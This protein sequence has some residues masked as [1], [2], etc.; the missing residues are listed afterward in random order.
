MAVLVVAAGSGAAWPEIGLPVAFAAAGYA[1]ISLLSPV[2][3]VRGRVL[4]PRAQH[5]AA[6]LVAGVLL[7]IVGAGEGLVHGCDLAKMLEQRLRDEIDVAR[8]G[9]Q[10]RLG[11][12]FQ[13]CAQLVCAR[14]RIV[15]LP[16]AHAVGVARLS[17]FAWHDERV[18]GW[19]KAARDDTVG[20]GTSRAAIPLSPRGGTP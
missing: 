2:R 20:I 16:S 4:T 11:Q 7:A 13:E 19:R 9:G 8:T 12:D 5:R 15:Q 6:L 10:L 14:A 18:F 1:A 17:G 3:I